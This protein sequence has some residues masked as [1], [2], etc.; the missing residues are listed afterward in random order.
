MLV[1][2][3][4]APFPGVNRGQHLD[5]H[6]GRPEYEVAAGRH[7]AGVA[8]HDGHDGDTGLHRQVECAF[9][10]G[11]HFRGHGA[12]A[13]RCQHHGA[14]LVAH[15]VHQRRHGLDGTARIGP[16]DEYHPADLQHLAEDG[17]FRLDLLF[18]DTGDILAQQLGD[19]DDVGL[20][21]VVEDE[22]RRAS[23]P[24]IL[25]SGHVELHTDQGAGGIGE[26]GEG[27]VQ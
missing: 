24:Q 7:V 16:V 20:A 27:K 10:E 1:H 18:A 8:N 5:I 11:R 12:G 14:P 26:Q 22:Y 4:H 2:G 23:R 9:L 25:L 15:G 3:V 19:D 21:L 13:L 17:C 6:G